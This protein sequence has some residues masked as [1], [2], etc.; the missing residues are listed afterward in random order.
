MRTKNDFLREGFQ[1]LNHYGQSDTQI[2]V[3]KNITTLHR[4]VVIIMYTSVLP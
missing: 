1:K 2:G 4:W 3:T